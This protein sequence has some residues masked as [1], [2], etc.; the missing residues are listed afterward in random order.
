[1]RRTTSISFE[2][3]AVIL[4]PLRR[5]PPEVFCEIFVWLLPSFNSAVNLLAQISHQWRAIAVSTP[6]LWSLFAINY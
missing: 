4:S 6:R 3:N 5:M 2:K 1:E